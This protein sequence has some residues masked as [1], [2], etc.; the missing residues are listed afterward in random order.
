LPAP[1]L[2]GV[3]TTATAITLQAITKVINMKV[4]KQI[5][6]EKTFDLPAGNYKATLSQIKSITKQSKRGPQE[7]VRLIFEVQVPSLTNQIPCAG[8]NFLLDLKKGSDLRNF[9]EGWLSA[10]FFTKL[11]G[12]VFD[13][14]TLLGKEADLVLTHFQTGDYDKP[15]VNVANA[16]PPG[17]LE[18]EK[19]SILSPIFAKLKRSEPAN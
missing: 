8:R 11:S 5:P 12:S 14:D 19:T 7:W 10:E 18:T 4:T 1:L 6:P 16:F 15:H 3:G 9:L 17:S 2:R 13:F